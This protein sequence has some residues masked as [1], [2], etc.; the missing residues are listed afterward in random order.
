[1]QLINEQPNAFLKFCPID[2]ALMQSWWQYGLRFGR[3]TFDIIYGYT[4]YMR[5]NFPLL[6]RFFFSPILPIVR[7]HL[8]LL[9]SRKAVVLLITKTFKRI[10]SALL[11]LTLSCLN[12][13][14]NSL[15]TKKSTQK[16]LW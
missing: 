5:V 13:N 11:L 12:S 9:L 16:M 14:S 15:F 3:P 6:S 2:V 1:M 4:K 10:D 7:D 8:V